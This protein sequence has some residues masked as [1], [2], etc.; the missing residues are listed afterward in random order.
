[1]NLSSERILSPQKVQTGNITLF[2]AEELTRKIR[3]RKT[4]LT[5]TKRPEPENTGI[6]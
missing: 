2:F 6:M 4:G 3:R 1:L 5:F